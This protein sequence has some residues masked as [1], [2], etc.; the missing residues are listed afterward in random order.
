MKFFGRERQ[1]DDLKGLWGKRVSSLCTCRGRRR[2]GKSTLIEQFAK[3]SN[4]RFIKVEGVRPK[5]GYTN[6]DELSAFAVQLSAQTGS[7][8]TTPENWL[9]A[10]IRLDKEIRD[11]EKTVVLID[12]ISWFG[13]YD[14]MFPDMVKIVWDNYWKKHDRLIVVLC[15]S[16][17]G[18]I[19]ENIIDNGAFYGRRSLDMVVGELPLSQCVKFW[20]AAAS[21]IETRE[22]LDVLSV[23]GGVPRYL[24]EVDPSLS[25]AD[26]IKKMAFRANSTLRTDFDEMF[27][28]V[29]TRQPRLSGRV[30]RR[31]AEGPMTVSELAESLGMEK[32][33][34]LSAALGQ[35]CEAGFVALDAGRNPETGAKLLL[36]FL[37]TGEFPSDATIAARY[38]PDATFPRR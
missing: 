36:G 15:G 26:N 5:D 14:A 3:M 9:N 10:F 30:I 12:E 29:V 4:A 22:M 24:E 37:S 34:K 25:A 20:G 31:L 17:S 2:I 13:Y 1:L 16:I 6:D 8:R 11:D 28:D 27:T 19:K 38:V 21:R 18:W 35:L 32:G 7:E 23:T 33:G